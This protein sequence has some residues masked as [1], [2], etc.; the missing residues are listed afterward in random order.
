MET[1]QVVAERGDREVGRVGL[2]FRFWR[3]EEVRMGFADSSFLFIPM[4]MTSKLSPSSSSSCFCFFF[5]FPA[6]ASSS[7]EEGK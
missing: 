6:I 5:S 1:T 3:R 4:P 2:R 7:S